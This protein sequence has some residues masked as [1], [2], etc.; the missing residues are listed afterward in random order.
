MCPRKQTTAP[1]IANLGIIFSGEVTSYTDTSYYAVPFL[2]AT[3][4]LYSLYMGLYVLFF[5]FYY[6][7]LIMY[8]KHIFS[9]LHFA[10]GGCLMDTNFVKPNN[11]TSFDV[12]FS[13]TNLLV[14]RHAK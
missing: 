5:I 8:I 9:M 2:W 12:Y 13:V 1:K 3:L 10:S 6:L 7:H 14:T 11:T 4:Y